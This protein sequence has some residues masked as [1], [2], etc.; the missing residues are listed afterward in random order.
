MDKKKVNLRIL[1]KQ[2][3]E[4]LEPKGEAFEKNSS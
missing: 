3:T 4:S 2:F 1:S